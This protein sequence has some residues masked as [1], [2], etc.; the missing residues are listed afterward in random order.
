MKFVGAWV[1]STCVF[2]VPGIAANKSL[3]RV[4][5][6]KLGSILVEGNVVPEHAPRIRLITVKGTPLL[7]FPLGE[8]G[9]P[10]ADSPL[11]PKV[12]AVLRTLPGVEGPLIVVAAA[13]PHATAIMYEVAIVGVVSGKLQ[14]LHSPWTVT[15][16][17]GVYVGDL[18]PGN[19]VGVA[20]WDF[21]WDNCH[22]CTH[23][24]NVRLYPW[25]RA[26]E[27]FSRQA[28]KNL[29]SRGAYDTD[30]KGLQD[31]GLNYTSLL[32]GISEFEGF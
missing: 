7:G 20:A 19:G 22:L 23:H 11:A 32:S 3:L 30:A 17:G 26:G 27:R 12:A 8:A 28:A 5:L 13:S 14:L 25:D 16:M 29:R 1:L 4:D 21:N 10:E 2:A 24:Y 15:D 9:P 18:G 6:P 31:L